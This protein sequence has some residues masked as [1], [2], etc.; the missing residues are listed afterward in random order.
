M[1]WMRD[2][3]LVCWLDIM[4]MCAVKCIKY[5]PSNLKKSVSAIQNVVFTASVFGN[6]A[7]QC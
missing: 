1:L 6:H 2:C 3:L 5:Q 4:A 7:M